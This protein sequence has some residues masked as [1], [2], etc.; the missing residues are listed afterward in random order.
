[1]DKTTNNLYYH[2]NKE[3][4]AKKLLTYYF[5]VDGAFYFDTSREFAWR[6]SNGHWIFQTENPH[7]SLPSFSDTQKKRNPWGKKIY[8]YIYILSTQR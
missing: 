1:M 4:I 7:N 8:M 5:T 3:I 2:I 6:L